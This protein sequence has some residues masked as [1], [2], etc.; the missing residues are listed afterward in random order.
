ML[1]IVLLSYTVR[2][3]TATLSGLHARFR[4]KP[5]TE[6]ISMNIAG[7]AYTPSKATKCHQVRAVVLSNQLLGRSR[8]PNWNRQEQD[9][10]VL[11]LVI[12]RLIFARMDLLTVNERRTA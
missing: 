8:G 7:T 11:G 6:S 12:Y 4:E 5:E 2:N 3:T 1:R 9:C 10:A